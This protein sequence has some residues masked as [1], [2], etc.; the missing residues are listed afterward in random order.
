MAQFFGGFTD[1]CACRNWQQGR[2][3]E[4]WSQLRIA[5]SDTWPMVRCFDVAMRR[6]LDFFEFVF[7]ASKAQ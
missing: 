2:Q 4:N 5:T 7:A 3:G 1:I 6:V